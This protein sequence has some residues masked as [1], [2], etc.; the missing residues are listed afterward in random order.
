MNQGMGPS[1]QD[2]GPLVL[3]VT[4]IML[5]LSTT[6]V[7]L[8]LVSRFGVVRRI[9]KD[10]YA[11]ILAWVCNEQFQEPTN[12]ASSSPFLSPSQCATAPRSV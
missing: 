1:A 8:R 7:V 3:T 9:S 2:R 4:I 12:N 5:C 10:D 11:M 6:S